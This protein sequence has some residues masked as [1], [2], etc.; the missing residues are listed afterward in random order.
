MG[1][2]FPKP[3]PLQMDNT[4]TESFAKNNAKK[5]KLKHIDAHQEWVPSHK[6]LEIMR[7]K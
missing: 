2:A 5:T 6:M 1:I 7:A 3:I 4:T